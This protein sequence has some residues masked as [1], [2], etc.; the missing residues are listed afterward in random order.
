VS[1]SGS[2]PL[3]SLVT[4]LPLEDSCSAWSFSLWLQILVVT[5][6]R[7]LPCHV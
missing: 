4:R 1:L 5:W 6:Y 7:W 2:R 3:W